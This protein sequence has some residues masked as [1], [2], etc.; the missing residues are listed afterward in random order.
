L[1]ED[2]ASMRFLH[3]LRTPRG[4]Q[5]QRPVEPSHAV[6]PRSRVNT[7]IKHTCYVSISLA[8]L[9]MCMRPWPC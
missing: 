7:V 1:P 8:N 4:D 3:L 5:S 2:E 9:T 6:S